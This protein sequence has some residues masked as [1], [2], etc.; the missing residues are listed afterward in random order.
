MKTSIH[1]QKGTIRLEEVRESMFL[2]KLKCERNSKESSSN[3]IGM[4]SNYYCFIKLFVLLSCLYKMLV[5]G[6]SSI[7]STSILLLYYFLNC[8]LFYSC[9]LP[10][11]Y[12]KGFPKLTWW[13]TY[14]T[15][16]KNAWIVKYDGITQI[17]I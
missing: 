7:P 5:L 12:T 16:N 10:D 1:G 6:V 2:K 17:E 3:N 11:N 4:K 14:E 8:F 13:S 15:F 9:R